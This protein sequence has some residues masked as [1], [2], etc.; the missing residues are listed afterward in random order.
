MQIE[1][2]RRRRTRAKTAAAQAEAAERLVDFIPR[3]SP[4]YMRP[5]HLG[6]LLKPLEDTETKAVRAIVNLPPRHSK[7]ETILHFIAR[8]LKRRPWETIAYVTYGAALALS[9]SRLARQYAL[10]AGVRLR[11]DATALH[12]WRTVENGGALFTSIGGTITGQGAQVIIIDDPHK[13][14]VEAE[15]ANM[16]GRVWDWW[17]GT[18]YDRLEPNG[19]VIACQTRWHPDDFTGRLLREQAQENWDHVCLPALG[20]DEGGVRI[21]DDI[22]G[23]PLWPER[24]PLD[25]LLKKRRNEYEWLSKFQQSPSKRGGNLFKGVS[26]YDPRSLPMGMEVSIGIDLAYSAETSSDHSAIVVLGRY[27]D[28]IFVL[29]A[30]REQ[31]TADMFVHVIAS[32]SQRFPSVPIYWHTSTTE[33]GT[34]N[35]MTSLAGIPVQHRLAKADKFVRALP[36]AAAWNLGE[37]LVPGGLDQYGQPVEVPAWVEPYVREQ[38]AFTGLDDPEDDQVDAGASAYSPWERRDAGDRID[39]DD[40]GY[41]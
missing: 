28:R 25:E 40:F 41:G 1:Q 26:F 9:K 19:S 14:R 23:T 12:E 34:A 16:R 13:D 38:L 30:Q 17:I 15:S 8:R 11:D 32:V 10:A 18:G 39:F 29:Y 22:N 31:M 3:V 33:R 7:T 24:W 6:R 27:G 20:R 36:F 2:E 35:L 4:R 37:V 5:T 21:A